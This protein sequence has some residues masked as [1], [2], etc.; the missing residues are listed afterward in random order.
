MRIKSTIWNIRK[1]KSFNQNSKK[2]KEFKKHEDRIRSLW[3]I[4]KCTNI[5]I[6]R[7]PKEEEEEQEIENLIQK[8]MKENFPNWVK[9]TDIQVQ[10][11]QSQTSW[12][13]RGPLQDTLELKCHRLKI[14]SLFLKYILLIML[15]QL[16]HYF[17]SLSLFTPIPSSIPPT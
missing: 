9:E 3:E 8:I 1:K 11:E 7:M 17:F 6:V 12:I 16:S 5:R 2:K 13:Q 15:L 10:K 14:E 4:S